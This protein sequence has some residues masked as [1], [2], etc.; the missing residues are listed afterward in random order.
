[1][2][3]LRLRAVR[4]RPKSQSTCITCHPELKASHW[5]EGSGT[6]LYPFLLHCPA[7]RRLRAVLQD[8]ACEITSLLLVGSFIHSPHAGKRK[9]WSSHR[10]SKSSEQDQAGRSAE[11]Q[12]RRRDRGPPTPGPSGT[13]ACPSDVAKKPQEMCHLG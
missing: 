10:I 8:E 7:S 12:E 4:G 3:K 13:P 1:M 11:S 6:F 5:L 9:T 2:S